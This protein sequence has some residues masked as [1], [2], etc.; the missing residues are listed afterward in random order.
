MT[1]AQLMIIIKAQDMASAVMKNVGNS[2]Q[3][4]ANNGLDRIRGAS[5]SAAKAVSTGLL[6]GLPL[7]GGLIAGMGAKAVQAAGQMESMGIAL[8]TAMGGNVKAAQEAQKNIVQFAAKTPYELEEV[9]GAFIKLKNMGLDPSNRALEAYGNT[10][11]AMGKGLNDMVE[12]V[13]DAATG[14]FERLKEFGIRA[15]NQGDK[16]AF[17]F[18]GVTT[19]VAKNSK[20]IENYLI[21]LGET[22]FA[23]GMEKQS[24]SLQGL[25]STLTDSINLK[26]AEFGSKL[27]PIIK[28]YIENLINWISSLNITA[29]F[30]FGGKLAEQ[31]FAI[32][33]ALT[34]GTD[35]FEDQ[36][37]ELQDALNNFGFGFT[38]EQVDEVV[39]NLQSTWQ[40]FFAVITGDLYEDMVPQFL[41]D[42]G[43]QFEQVDG[44]IQALHSVWKFFSTDVVA[45]QSVMIGL[46]AVVGTIVIGAFVSMAAAVIAATWPFIAL[47]AVV[48]GLYYAWQTNFYGMRDIALN[49]VSTMQNVWN[50]IQPILIMLGDLF[51]K[52][53]YPS[54]VEAAKAL[55]ALWE[56][57]APY[58]IPTLQFLA[59]VIGAVLIGTIIALGQYIKILADGAKIFADAFRN[60]IINIEGNFNRLRSNAQSLASFF[61]W[62]FSSIT[63][64]VVGAFNWAINGLIMRLNWAIDSVNA[65]INIA[66]KIPGAG[67]IP[68][69]PRIPQFANGVRNFS[70]GA[71]IVGERGPELVTLPKG[72]NVFSNG[73]TQ[74]ILGSQLASTVVNITVQ[75]GM[76]NNDKDKNDLV[77]SLL[78]TLRQNGVQIA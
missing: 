3:N 73:E 45:Q 72:S 37:G 69:I 66:K 70:G 65:V 39:R 44:V 17:T 32:G 43:V 2:A 26:L 40:T 76:F 9:M 61:S 50:I 25:I 34:S 41:Y 47:G 21:R 24:R 46:A 27:L 20:D 8:E 53:V 14:E 71:A 15:S 52:H 23:G 58:V 29:F 13:A 30:D 56:V 74:N 19:T 12:A 57:L 64:G 28:P 67:F 77:K 35:I 38:F 18:K 78:Y 63:S 68:N 51:M 31:I 49:L 36:I 42:W 11:S 33:K 22:N 59:V 10:A 16:V 1:D 54:L 48:G 75:G 7:V 55:Y 6:V 4:L 62:V 5:A 60:A